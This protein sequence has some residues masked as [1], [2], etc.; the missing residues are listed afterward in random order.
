MA[1]LRRGTQTALSEAASLRLRAA[2]LYYNHALTQKEVAE[3]L[4][5]SRTTD[6]TRTGN[7]L[8][9]RLPNAIDGW[10]NVEWLPFHLQ[11]IEHLSAQQAFSH[12]YDATLPTTTLVEALAETMNR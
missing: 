9:L 8:R 3:Q 12:V 1:K 2:W 5:I 11:N 10:T 6:P 4:G 7:E